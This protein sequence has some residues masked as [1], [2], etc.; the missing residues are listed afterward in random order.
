MKFVNK[1]DGGSGFE[2]VTWESLRSGD[3]IIVKE[4]ELFPADVLILDSVNSSN[5]HKCYVRGG[6]HDSFNFPTP[7][8]ACE[9]TYNR[10]G[11]RMSSRK[12]VE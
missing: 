5:D 8:K 7:K 12:L 11:M 9:G 6:I 1:R 4:N 10:P 3:I 2:S